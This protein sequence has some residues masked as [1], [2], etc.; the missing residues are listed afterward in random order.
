MLILFFKSWHIPG[1]VHDGVEEDQIDV[2]EHP[3]GRINMAR[4]NVLL[5]APEIHGSVDQ[6][7]VFGRHGVADR[8]V[9]EVGVL[10]LHDPPQHSQDRLLPHLPLNLLCCQL[11]T[12]WGTLNGGLDNRSRSRLLDWGLLKFLGLAW[13]NFL[14][15]WLLNL[16]SDLL[17]P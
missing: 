1:I 17:W 9:E 7:P 11:W 4:F 5:D 13:L 16:F 14:G 6:V 8:A 3:F 10:V 15:D 2:P 12:C